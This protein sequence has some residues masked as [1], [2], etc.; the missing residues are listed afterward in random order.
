M[1]TA[2]QRQNHTVRNFNSVQHLIRVLRQLSV[3]TITMPLLVNAKTL[4]DESGLSSNSARHRTW[5][6]LLSKHLK[7]INKFQQPNKL[8]GIVTG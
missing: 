2:K 4:V 5:H 3:G 8:L 7:R 1:K 6:P